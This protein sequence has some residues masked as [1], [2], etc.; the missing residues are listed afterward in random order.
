MYDL[1]GPWFTLIDFAGDGRADAVLEAAAAQH[2]PVR[3]CVVADPGARELWERDL[4]LVRPDQ[5]VAWRGNRSPAN[6]AAVVRRVRGVPTVAMS[7][8][9]RALRDERTTHA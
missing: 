7:T 3:H 8:K 6:P 1:F 5:H 4:V 2:L 9:G